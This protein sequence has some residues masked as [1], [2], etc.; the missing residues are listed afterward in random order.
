MLSLF[1]CSNHVKVGAD[2]LKAVARIKFLEPNEHL[3][4]SK[5]IKLIILLILIV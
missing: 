4:K 2:G 1:P 3:V 5:C